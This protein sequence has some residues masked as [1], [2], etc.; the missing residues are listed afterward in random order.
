MDGVVEVEPHNSA[1]RLTLSTGTVPKQILNQLI[2]AGIHVE[3]F[4]IAIPTLDEIFIQV[5]QEPEASG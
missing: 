3:W 2:A 1:Y 4:E 5:V